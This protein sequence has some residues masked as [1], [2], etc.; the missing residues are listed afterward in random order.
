MNRLAAAWAF[1]S[2]IA[3][4]AAATPA[5]GKTHNGGG[6]SAHGTSGTQDGSV[7]HSI[8]SASSASPHS[9]STWRGAIV[10]R[11][12]PPFHRT[13]GGFH[14][15]PHHPHGSV[16]FFIVS[17]FFVPAPFAYPFYLYYPYSSL[18][19]FEGPLGYGGPSI[20][21][22]D[23]YYCWIDA[24]GFSNEGQFAQ[25]LHDVHGIPLDEALSASELVGGRYV[26]LG[27]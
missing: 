6:H 20:I 10:T 15:R 2:A 23:P 1:A 17:P 13:S 25:H 18:Y 16:F 5:F 24:V 4:M 8:M 14:G 21:I 22:S 19:E 7:A 26:F 27:Y 11:P 3:Y 9:Q 12:A